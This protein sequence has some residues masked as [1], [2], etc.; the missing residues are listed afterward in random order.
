MRIAVVKVGG[1][2][3]DDP[4]QAKPL[5]QYLHEQAQEQPVVIVHGGGNAVESL[6][7]E[8]G[9]SSEKID[10]LRVTPEHQIDYVVGAL[11]G[12]V[13]KTLCGLAISMGL[14]PVGL[15][16]ADGRMAHSQAISDRLGRVGEVHSGDAT[17]LTLLLSHNFLPVVSSI[18]ADQQGRL[19]NINADQAA[20][21]LAK[22]LQADL[23][24]LSDVPGVLDENKSLLT[25]LDDQQL[26]QLIDTGVV[27]DG[28]VVKVNAAMEAAQ[29]LGCPVTIAS[30]R[31]PQGLLSAG[32]CASGTRIIPKMNG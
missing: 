19:L 6:L 2:F 3:L 27:R 21:A 4:E 20:T 8:L 25:S 14:N 26:Q 9:Q 10:G 23:Y 1:A 13:N 24:L 7:K 22:T 15:S 12:T 31:T 5:L 16:L 32:S 11:A 17:L 29:A 30:W 18:G 28:M